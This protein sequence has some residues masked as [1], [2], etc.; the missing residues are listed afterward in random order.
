VGVF[1]GFDPTSLP[2]D[3]ANRLNDDDYESRC[4]HSVVHSATIPDMAHGYELPVLQSLS[5]LAICCFII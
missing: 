4:V 2:S 5:S 3:G 1:D